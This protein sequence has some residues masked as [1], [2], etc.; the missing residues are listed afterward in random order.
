MRDDPGIMFGVDGFQESFDK[1]HLNPA[2]G[3][4]QYRTSGCPFRVNAR[5]SGCFSPYL[6]SLGTN[7]SKEME[8]EAAEADGVLF[9]D[10][11]LY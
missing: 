5:A 2:C 3:S 11:D 10:A 9:C 6:E 7:L 8:E 1:W 4:R